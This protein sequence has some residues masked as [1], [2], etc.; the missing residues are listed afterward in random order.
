MNPARST[1]VGLFAGAQAISQ[2]WFF[3]LTPIIGGLLGGVIYR[4]LGED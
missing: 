3:W 4:W 2:L 1:G